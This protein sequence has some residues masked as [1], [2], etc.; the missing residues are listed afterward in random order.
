V[1]ARLAWSGAGAVVP[2]R[3]LTA[4]RLRAAIEGVLADPEVRVQARRL[5]AAIQRCG[6]VV[7][8]ADLIERALA[9]GRPVLG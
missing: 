2:L 9:S 7:R 1:A 8:A 3:Q 5:Q 4:P 6:G